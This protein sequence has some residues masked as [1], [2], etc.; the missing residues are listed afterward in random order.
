LMP[1]W[2]RRCLLNQRLSIRASSSSSI[3]THPQDKSY[4]IIEW[5]IGMIWV[6][7]QIRD[8]I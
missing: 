3:V 5:N 8:G 4:R 1:R 2:W 7:S 6:F